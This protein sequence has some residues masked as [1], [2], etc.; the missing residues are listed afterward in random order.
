MISSGEIIGA[1]LDEID[2][3]GNKL[4]SLEVKGSPLRKALEE[5]AKLLTHENEDDPSGGFLQVSGNS[6]GF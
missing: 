5:S 6:I 1:N 3:F 4:D 2:P